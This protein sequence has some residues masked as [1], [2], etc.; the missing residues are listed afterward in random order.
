MIVRKRVASE[1]EEL[2]AWLESVA[3]ELRRIGLEAGPFIA[4]ALCG[5]A[6]C[7]ACGRAFEARHV[8]NAFK[9]M[10]VKTDC[11]DA[12]GVAELLRLGWF[13]PV[14][15]SRWKPNGTRDADARTLEHGTHSPLRE[16]WI[17]IQDQWRDPAKFRPRGMAAK[18]PVRKC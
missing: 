9:I 6:K 3:L 8:R 11:K 15:A 1:P 4:V 13:H 14:H 18:Q 7:G 16:F 10:P 12:H 17:G 5:D 2:I